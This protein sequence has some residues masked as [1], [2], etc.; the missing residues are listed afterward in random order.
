MNQVVTG[1][2]QV[3]IEALMCALPVSALEPNTVA[4]LE[5]FIDMP[6]DREPGE[7]IRLLEPPAGQCVP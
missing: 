2:Q 7:V 3:D 4:T 1:S 6:T 5:A